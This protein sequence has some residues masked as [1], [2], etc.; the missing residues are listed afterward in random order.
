MRRDRDRDGVQRHALSHQVRL[1]IMG[2]FTRDRDRSLDADDLHAD[3]LAA[4]PDT[5]RHYNAGQV[6][7]HRVVL[8]E[9]QL[10]PA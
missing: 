1:D 4:A 5:Y 6:F 8:Q 9:A 3:L 10:L 2:L 7:Y